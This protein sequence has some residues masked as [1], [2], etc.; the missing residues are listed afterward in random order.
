MR[1][2]ALT[3]TLS[4]A[5]DMQRSPELLRST[6]QQMSRTPK[7]PCVLDWRQVTELDSAALSLVL[8]LA[9]EAKRSGRIIEHLALPPAFLSLA[10]LYG[11]DMLF[12]SGEKHA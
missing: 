3:I 6:L 5:V 8:E 11:A 4:G 7:A 9:R 10:R 2:E 1:P 12:L